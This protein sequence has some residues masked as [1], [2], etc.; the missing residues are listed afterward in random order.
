MQPKGTV[1]RSLNRLSVLR[2]ALIASRRL[3]LTR[4]WG[5][6]LDRTCQFSLSTK[7][8]KT[9][10][11]GVHVGAHS[12]VAFEARILCHDLTRGLYLETRVGRDCF[13]GGRSLLMPGVTVGDGSIVGAGAVVTKDVPARSIVVGNPAEVI[14]RDIE[15]G[16]YGRFPDADETQRRLLIGE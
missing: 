2:R 5:M 14:R 16:H 7:F 8:D 3:Y 12:Y 15:V 11:K 1:R 13:I 6:D 4:I 10:P 9:Y